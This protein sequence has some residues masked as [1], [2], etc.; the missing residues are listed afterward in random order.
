MTQKSTGLRPHLWLAALAAVAACD[1]TTK[2]PTTTFDP[3]ALEQSTREVA[4]A[5]ENNRAI[6]TMDVMGQKM[7]FGAPVQTALSLAPSI[8]SGETWVDWGRRQMEALRRAHNLAVTSPAAIIPSTLLGKT[9]IYNPQTDRYEISNRTGAPANGVRFILYAVDPVQRR[10]VTPVNEIGYLDLTDESTSQTMTL[11]I[12]AVID[13]Q[14]L[15]DYDFS[16]SPSGT[17]ATASGKGFLSDGVTR[18]D[19]EFSQSFSQTTGMQATYKL[20]APQKGVSLELR[21]N[22][23]PT[24]SGTINFTIRVGNDT[25]VFN[26]SGTFGP[27]GESRPIDGTITYNGE[28]V[29]KISGTPSNPVFTDAG[30]NQLQPGQSQA[31]K[32]LGDLIGDVL[33]AFDDL[34]KPMYRLFGMPMPA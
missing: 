4:A 2:E 8:A 33:D 34:L 5:M 6:Q 26:V 20:T 21:A 10:V 1:L 32:K 28:V 22:F 12:K 24:F 17:G 19:F 15:L 29:V 30:G 11:G 25:V 7:S 31:L 14:T 23:S 9:F 13:N 16:A 27:D 3:I 18:V